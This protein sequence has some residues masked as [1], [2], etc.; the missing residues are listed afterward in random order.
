[1]FPEMQFANFRT[2]TIEVSSKSF[3]IFLKSRECST[4]MVSVS[5][6]TTASEL[7][8]G[9]T[10]NHR[11]LGCRLMY[12]NHLLDSDIT[13]SAYEIRFG[14]IL[15]VIEAAEV[16]IYGDLPPFVTVDQLAAAENIKNSISARFNWP[17]EEQRLR[18]KDGKFGDDHELFLYRSESVLSLVV[19]R[20]EVDFHVSVKV[21]QSKYRIKLKP[22][23]TVAVLKAKLEF[24]A[25]IPKEKQT[26]RFEREILEDSLKMFE[27]GIKDG[28]KLEMDNDRIFIHSP[29]LRKTFILHRLKPSTSVEEIKK[30]IE[31][32]EGIPFDQ[33]SLFFT[34]LK[35]PLRYDLT[36]ENCR[37]KIGNQRSETNRE[38]FCGKCFTV[39]FSA[40]S[41]APLCNKIMNCKHEP[42]KLADDFMK[43]LLND[44]DLIHEE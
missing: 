19:T 33:L 35:K 16:T 29:Q 4:E 43:F 2:K 13:F 23:D 10:R 28:S 24:V 6:S 27:C 7:L 25:D 37:V 21:Q 11:G 1:M 8:G 40:A 36:L 18:F 17:K 15:H 22:S 41:S 5:P 30:G 26:L 44:L 39:K 31:K 12:K 38:S 34:N 32:E 9:F 42:K 14:A 3:T 20:E